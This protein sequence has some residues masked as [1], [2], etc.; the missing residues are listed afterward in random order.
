[1]KSGD[2]LLVTDVMYAIS[3]VL[4]LCRSVMSFSCWVLNLVGEEGSRSAVGG[5]WVEEK[6]MRSRRE[7]M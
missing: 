3:A 7:I 6:E 4:A 2:L 1:M 5:S